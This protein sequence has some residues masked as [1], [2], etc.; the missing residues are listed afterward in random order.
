MEHNMETGGC[1]GMHV[2]IQGLGRFREIL[3]QLLGLHGVIWGHTGLR[4]YSPSPLL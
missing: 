3:S 4:V 1:I 2:G